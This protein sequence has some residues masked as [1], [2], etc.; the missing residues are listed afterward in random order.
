MR[1]LF[2]L[3]N[4]ICYLVL[5]VSLL[6]G[7]MAHADSLENTLY[8]D[9]TRIVSQQIEILK[10]RLVQSKNELTKLQ[11]QQDNLPSIDNVNKQLLSQASLDVAVARSNL[12]SVNIELSE[13]QQSIARLEKE[14]QEIE[15]QLNVYNIFGLKMASNGAPNLK[16][17]RVELTYQK[18]LLQLEKTRADSLLELQ[19]LANGSLQLYKA[20][21]SRIEVL[22]KS[23]TMMRLKEQ[24]AKSEISFQQ[25]QSY[26]LQQQNVLY[27]Q[28]SE[29]EKTKQVKSPAYEKLENDIFYANENVNFTY[30]QML[31]ARYQDQIHQFKVSVSRSSSITLLNKVSEQ[32]QLLVKQLVRV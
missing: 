11:H 17:L 21:Y 12:D 3:R 5:A 25:Q 30:L 18:N 9:K 13:S 22:L 23:Q 20:R 26:W 28:L 6:L 24:Q 4:F 1:K 19:T 29:L 15:N 7:A 14:V 2:R 27:A 32:A 8:Q 16:N 31:I 10:N